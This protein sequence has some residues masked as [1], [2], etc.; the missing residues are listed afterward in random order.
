MTVRFVSLVLA[1]LVLPAG[2]NAQVAKQV[3]VT[4]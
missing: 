3:G 2:A 1:A 4:Q